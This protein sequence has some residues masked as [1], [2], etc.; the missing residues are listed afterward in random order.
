[1]AVHNAEEW[2]LGMTG[3]VA[4][5]P[6]MPGRFLHGD[7]QQFGVALVIVTAAVLTIGVIAV[8]TR[9]KWSAETLVCVAYALIINAGS[10]LLFSVV[11]WSLMPGVISGLF[12]LLPLG[13]IIVRTLPPVRWSTSAVVTTVIAAVGIVA[14]SLLIAAALAPIIPAL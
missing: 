13:L 8:S 7:Q 3:W 5:R 1:M 12:V 11:S 9:A 4:A 14:G 6:W 2:L 10:H